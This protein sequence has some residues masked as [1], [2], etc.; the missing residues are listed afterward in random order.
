M[1]ILITGTPCTGKSVVAEKLLSKLESIRKYKLKTIRYINITKFIIDKKIA[2]YYDK[3]N[4]CNVVDIKKLNKA[5]L[6]LLD[7]IKYKQHKANELIIIDSH[8]LFL[9]KKLVD[10]AVVLNCNLKTLNK[11]LK[12]RKYS[13]QKIKDNIE[14]EIVD[15]CYNE[16]IDFFYK[17]ILKLDNTRKKDTNAIIKIIIKKIN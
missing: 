6:K 12:S 1:I 17:N 15:Y 9:D 14:S 16:C 8:I 13:G 10:L 2:D 3:K 4:K 5:V 7:E 11:R